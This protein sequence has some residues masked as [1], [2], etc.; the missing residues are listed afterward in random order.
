VTECRF[1]PA[2]RVVR[3]SSTKEAIV[4]FML[5]LYG[6]P[7]PSDAFTPELWQRVVA[8]HTDFAARLTAADALV[9]SAPLQPVESARTVRFLR[10]ERLVTDGPF[11]ETKETLGGYYLIDAGSLDEAVAWAESFDSPSD[12]SIEVRPLLD[13]TPPAPA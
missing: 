12:G 11:A 7:L 6:E 3:T 4:R 5:L 8:A 2:P 13:L 9:D 10:R 1:L